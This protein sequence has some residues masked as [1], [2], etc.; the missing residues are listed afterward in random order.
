MADKREMIVSGFEYTGNAADVHG[1]FLH[2][3]GRLYWC[4]GR[5]GHKVTGK[6]GKVVH[7]GLAS[8]IWSCKPDG[9]DVQWH[10]LGCGDNPVEVDFTPEGDIIGVQ[11]LYYSQPR[12]D[13][14]VHWL[15]GGVYERADQMK[16]IAGLPR[17]LEHMP[18]MYNFGHVAVSGCCFWR[19]RLSPQSEN[20]RTKNACN[21]MVTHFNT[22]RVVRME[23]TPDGAT[24]K[25]TEN[26]FLKP[27]R[28]RRPLHRCAGGRATAPSSSSTPAAGSASGAR[29]SLMAKPDAA[30]RGVSG[31]KEGA[32]R[33]KLA[34]AHGDGWNVSRLHCDEKEC[35]PWPADKIARFIKDD[36]PFV[37]DA[38]ARALGKFHPEKAWLFQS[39]LMRHQDP[40]VRSRAVWSA[41]LTEDEKSALLLNRAI[42]S[43]DEALVH[44]AL[45]AMPWSAFDSRIGRILEGFTPDDW[46][47]RWAL[48]QD[49]SP[50]IQRLLCTA[51]LMPHSRGLITSDEAL[52]FMVDAPPAQ[53]HAAILWLGSIHADKFLRAELSKPGNDKLKRTLLA[54]LRIKGKKLPPMSFLISP[55]GTNASPI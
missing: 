25:A 41:A 49:K 34:R 3:N 23:L 55:P 44:T 33:G 35:K 18:V 39:E 31:E 40:R 27:P 10:S 12:G 51:D 30:G 9:S 28:P 8:G 26:E 43:G 6:D 22:Q 42:Y 38:A 45:N 52:K 4:H 5:K 24:Y 46:T 21:F 14:L 50:L 19:Y 20:Q 16:A 13:T 1:P 54:A 53:E 48:M 2:P 7:E 47:E 36:R 15:Y 11:N 17:T 32:D 29:R 37:A